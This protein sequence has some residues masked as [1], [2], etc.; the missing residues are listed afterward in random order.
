MYSTPTYTSLYNCHLHS[1][2]QILKSTKLLNNP[3]LFHAHWPWPP[4]LPLPLLP[5]QP[6][7]VQFFLQY[8]LVT[9]K[10]NWIMYGILYFSILHKGCI[11]KW[12]Q[13]FLPC[14]LIWV[15]SLPPCITCYSNISTSTINITDSIPK[16]QDINLKH[17]V[18][19]IVYI[20]NPIL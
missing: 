9:I 19:S 5:L 6:S 1:Q 3:T 12:K 2:I 17:W 20:D 11:M 10:W 15:V 16:V 7:D 14:L 8:K 13:I 4:L 18:V